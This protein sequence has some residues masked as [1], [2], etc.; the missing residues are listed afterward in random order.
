MMN[1]YPPELKNQETLHD[2]NKMGHLNLLPDQD[3]HT[4]FSL[5]IL[6]VNPE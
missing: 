3:V 1:I 6:L 2:R 4:M 5:V